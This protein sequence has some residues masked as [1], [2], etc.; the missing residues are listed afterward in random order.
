MK[1]YKSGAQ[2]RKEAALAKE[3]AQKLTKVTHYFS[4]VSTC[5]R[6]DINRSETSSID[7]AETE[8]LENCTKNLPE[9]SISLPQPSF[10]P[11]SNDPVFWPATISD[12]QRCDIIKR[13][14]EQINIAF[15][16]NSAKRRFSSVHYECT[17]INGKTIHR[18]WLLYSQQSD[19]IFCFCCKL[20]GNTASP[21]CSGMNTWEG[22]SKKLKDHENS[23]F[24]KKCFSQ[25]MLLKEGI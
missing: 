4:A 12:A 18:S 16:Y 5:V 25:W 10:I 11:L 20:F 19:Q 2:K 6:D 22:I 17:M 21:F 24:Y 15:P 23:T 9:T 14:S 13:G 8:P 7:N 3:S 1:K